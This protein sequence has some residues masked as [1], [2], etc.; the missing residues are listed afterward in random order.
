[1]FGT[2]LGEGVLS[3]LLPSLPPLLPGR[4]VWVSLSVSLSLLGG[5]LRAC[6]SFL[7]RAKIMRLSK[8][9][10]YPIRPPCP[11]T[12][13][14]PRWLAL[15]PPV[16][17]SHLRGL[18][19]ICC[20]DF[21]DVPR[22]CVARGPGQE[23]GD[24]EE[25]GKG[26]GRYFHQLYAS[27]VP[28]PR[29]VSVSKLCLCKRF[30]ACVWLSLSLSYSLSLYLSVSL[31]FPCLCVWLMVLAV[32]SCSAFLGYACKIA[33]LDRERMRKCSLALGPAW[34]LQIAFKLIANGA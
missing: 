30:A 17:L 28:S 6:K 31:L 29:R 25:K 11:A 33:V 14:L 32:G 24:I 34:G 22:M 7:L 5:S 13:P 26:K 3:S 8:V 10:S 27:A 12:P 15:M 2:P 23:A 20:R 4:E 16:V 21:Q 19:A 18:P 9:S 1:M